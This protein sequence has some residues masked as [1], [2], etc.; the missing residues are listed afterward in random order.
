MSKILLLGGTSDG[1]KLAARLHKAGFQVI[2]SVA[3]LVRMPEL[4]CEV[5]SGG[6]SQF[7]PERV[8]DKEEHNPS[9]SGLVSFLKTQ[10]VA[11]ILD[12]THPYAVNMSTHAVQAAE[13]EQIPCW[14]FH[15]PAWEM[16]EGDRWSSFVDWHEM[17]QQ[18]RSRQGG[19]LLTTGQLTQSE[20]DQLMD[21]VN[22]SAVK[23]TEL[24]HGKVSQGSLDR[25]EPEPLRIV[26]RT[27]A[28]SRVELPEEIHWIKAIGPFDA[29]NEKALLE[30]H[31]IQV[32][33]SK[34]SGGKATQGKLDAARALG[35]EV[36]MLQRPELPEATRSFSDPDQVFAELISRTQSGS[37]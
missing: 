17:L 28:P 32:V 3:G 20:L 34:N 1:R 10:Q 9:V 4:D 37:L 27:A 16:Q 13:A 35:I 31:G 24:S 25:S 30:E 26:M 23:T 6:F 18:L 12:V 19:V 15:R 22:Q 33:V 8:L 11:L 14:R 29:G 36:F 21:A 7:A 2:Y 5:I